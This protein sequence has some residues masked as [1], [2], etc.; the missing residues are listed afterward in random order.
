MLKELNC[1][2]IGILTKNYDKALVKSKKFGIPNTYTSIQEILN[3]ECDFFMNL[4]SAD[5]ISSTIMDL[6]PAGKP[7]F[8]EKPAGFSTEEI[9]QL[10][11]QNNK[12]NCPI[13]VGTNRR[14][15][16]CLLYTSPSPRD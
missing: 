1:D 2:V 5:K 9:E 7:I 11:V 15:Y 14:F 10:I 13:M 6:I 16:S 12:F 8:T 4:T 3:A